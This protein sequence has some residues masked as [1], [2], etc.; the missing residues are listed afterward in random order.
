MQPLRIPLSNYRGAAVD[1]QTPFGK[2][3]P[4]WAAIIAGILSAAATGFWV[5]FP[6]ILL[7][8][9][10]W[11]YLRTEEGPPVL[12]LAFTHHWTQIT[13]GLFYF[14]L[15]HRPMYRFGSEDPTYVTWLALIGAG[16]LLL[17]L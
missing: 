10:A 4:F 12:A 9:A 16:A 8:W 7:L 6:A 11:R 1:Q 14:P 17:G 5:T 2:L 15:F 3:V 13:L